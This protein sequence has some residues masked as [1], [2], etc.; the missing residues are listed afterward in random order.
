MKDHMHS[1]GI[2]EFIEIAI[3]ATIIISEHG[4]ITHTNLRA[5]KLFEYPTGELI[6]QP[7]EVLVPNQYRHK[8]ASLRQSFFDNPT[9]REMGK[10]VDLT[11][12]TKLGNDIP[13]SIG[14]S[15][16]Q[17]VEQQFQVLVSIRDNAM[18]H[19]AKARIDDYISEIRNITETAIDAIITMDDD[20]TILSWNNAATH[21]FGYTEEEAIGQSVSIIIPKNMRKSHFNG[22]ANISSEKQSKIIGKTV[23]VE[24]LRK[25]GDTFPLSLSVSNWVSK[26]GR[27]F[28]GILRDISLRVEAEKKITEQNKQLQLISVTDPLTG[29]F[30]RRQFD[31]VGNEEFARCR[32]GAKPYTILMLDIDHFKVINDIYGHALGDEAIIETVSIIKQTIRQQDSLFRLGGEEFAIILPET[33]LTSS[34]KLAQRIRVSIENIEI[35]TAL[36]NIKYTI[37]IGVAEF[38]ARDE[39]ITTTLKHADEALYKAKSLGRNRVE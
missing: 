2:S 5:D 36:G 26:R 1:S 38:S 34:Q 37:S 4:I 16:F 33:S 29:A 3:D 18:L 13:V 8:H 30:N 7:I 12:K 19:E 23:E 10:Y 25:N 39:N 35:H 28:C 24:G 17:G 31:L 14:L 21:L 9:I 11:A 6:G 22:V 20:S 32:R 27:I 15:P